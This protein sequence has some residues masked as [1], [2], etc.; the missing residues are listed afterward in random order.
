MTLGEIRHNLN[1]L[2]LFS[3]IEITLDRDCLHSSFSFGTSLFFAFSS[4]IS[5]VEVSQVA[6]Y[7]RSPWEGW[8]GGTPVSNAEWDEDILQSQ[9]IRPLT[10]TALGPTCKLTNMYNSRPT[11]PLASVSDVK[12]E[13]VPPSPPP[14]KKHKVELRPAPMKT[15]KPQVLAGPPPVQAVSPHPTVIES[16]SSKTDE[17]STAS[18]AEKPE[19]IKDTNKRDL[20]V[21]SQHGILAPPPEGS[22]RFYKL[23]HQAKELFKFYYRGLKLINTNRLRVNE[24]TR[25]VKAGGPPLTRWETRFI[26]TYRADAL[27]LIPFALIIIVIE[28]ILPLVVLYTPFLLPSTCILPSQKER[29]DGKKR[30]KQQGYALTMHSV[31][32]EI[33]QKGQSD[34]S[35]SVQS[36]LEGPGLTSMSGLLGIPTWGP[37]ALVR[38][39]FNK[40]LTSVRADDALLIKE[41]MGAS[42]TRSE[43]REALEERGLLTEGFT[44]KQW[45]SRLRWWLSHVQSAETAENAD[46]VRERIML[47]SRGATGRF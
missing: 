15:P 33:F 27:K 20:E 30:G 11:P 17:A 32:E 26:Q 21:A 46:P 38:Y 44:I 8:V 2:C 42:L 7:D 45:Q 39:R 28:E 29:I 3:C 25:R 36:L 23:F 47:V 18:S 13:G 5:G 31:F 40:H 12:Q 14:L 10:I 16:Q 19:S 22:S 9:D 6:L 41:D 37:S 24:M 34:P 43:L 1:C 35:L 4:G